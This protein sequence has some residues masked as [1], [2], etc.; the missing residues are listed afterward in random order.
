MSNKFIYHLF[1]N[2]CSTLDEYDNLK[3]EI[4]GLERCTRNALKEYICLRLDNV[5]II[6]TN[7]ASIYHEFCSNYNIELQSIPT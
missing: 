7:S 2:L 3:L 6:I 5:K 4:A 1:E